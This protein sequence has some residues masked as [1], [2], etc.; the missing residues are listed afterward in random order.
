MINFRIEYKVNGVSKS[1]NSGCDDEVITIEDHLSEWIGSYFRGE[2][3][4]LVI[5]NL[6]SGLHLDYS[7]V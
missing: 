2:I 5:H 4:N 7:K 3:T 1:V 6:T